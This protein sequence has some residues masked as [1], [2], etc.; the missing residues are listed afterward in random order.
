[1][2][3]SVERRND[4]SSSMTIMM[5]FR[6]SHKKRS[7][8]SGS[9]FLEK[10]A[11]VGRAPDPGCGVRVCLQSSGFGPWR[12][13]QPATRT[14]TSRQVHHSMW[15]IDAHRGLRDGTADAQAHSQSVRFGGVERRPKS[16]SISSGLNPLPKSPTV[17]NRA[18]RP[19]RAHRCP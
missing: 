4:A 18:D 12:P 17:V 10:A 1:M 13:P 9:G 5:G 16:R 6:F 15:P 14:K 7:G 8:D 19:S 11:V 2:S 3:R